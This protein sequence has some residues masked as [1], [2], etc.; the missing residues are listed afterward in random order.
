[1]GLGTESS[2][3]QA[4][5]RVWFM[6]MVV[7]WFILFNGSISRVTF[8]SILI[9]QVQSS[10]WKDPDLKFLRENLQII[11]INILTPCQALF[12]VL[13]HRGRQKSDFCPQGVYILWQGLHWTPYVNLF[14][15]IGKQRIVSAID[16]K[17][18]K[19]KKG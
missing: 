16:L 12:Y 7:L 2:R 14:I 9:L 3:F 17:K 11:L 18:T 1:M 19:N 5:A 4:S 8:W 6:Q 10:S 13:E 15:F